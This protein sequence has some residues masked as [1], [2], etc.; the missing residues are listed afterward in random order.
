MAGGTAVV[1]PSGAGPGGVGMGHTD[2]YL[3]V[4]LGDARFGI[5]VSR[6]KEII[7]CDAITPL[8][9]A[10]AAVRGTINLRGRVVPVVDLAVRFGQG[11]MTIGRRTCIVIAEVEGSRRDRSFD[12]G[13]LIDAVN[14]VVD[15]APGDIEP[16]PTMDG[17]IRTDFALGMGKVRGA[18]VL[19]LKI[20]ALVAVAEIEGL[21]SSMP[22]PP[23]ETG[24]GSHG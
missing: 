4:S 17:S 21:T 1:A 13:L 6:V 8:P 2:K 24:G 19:L 16:A 20:E 22:L 14:E 5:P 7:E 18:F 15:I 23:P 12:F 9:M 3:T 10:P 11:P